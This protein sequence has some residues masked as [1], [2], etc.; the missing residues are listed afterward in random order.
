M[1]L[2]QVDLTMDCIGSNSLARVLKVGHHGYCMST[3]TGMEQLAGTHVYYY[4]YC[5]YCYC[6][7]YEHY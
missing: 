7:H 5:C 6:Y 3:F 2:E 1:Q 4:Y